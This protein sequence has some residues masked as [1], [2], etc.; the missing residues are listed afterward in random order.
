MIKLEEEPRNSQLPLDA[1]YYLPSFMKQTIDNFLKY[2]GEA[3][4]EIRELRQELGEQEWTN[5]ELKVSVR[6]KSM[7]IKLLLTKIEKL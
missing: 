1:K 4:S 6:E 7:Q 2:F 5:R 3:I